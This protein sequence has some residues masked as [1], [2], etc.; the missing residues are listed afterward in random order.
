MLLMPLRCVVWLAEKI[1]NSLRS[2]QKPLA[3]SREYA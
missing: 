1:E 2:D 3:A